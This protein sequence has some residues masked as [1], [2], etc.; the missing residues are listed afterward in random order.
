MNFEKKIK[1]KVKSRVVFVFNVKKFTF[2]DIVYSQLANKL[3]IF[4]ASHFDNMLKKIHAL[5]RLL[6]IDNKKKKQ[7]AKKRE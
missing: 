1:K 7:P 3:L 6:F 5:G 4:F 2:I